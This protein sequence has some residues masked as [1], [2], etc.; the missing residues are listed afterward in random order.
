MTN[1]SLSATRID[2]AGGGG[3]R[4]GSATSSMRRIK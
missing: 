3:D 2:S 1:Y 4:G